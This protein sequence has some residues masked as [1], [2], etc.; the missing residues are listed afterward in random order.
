L[1]SSS[2]GDTDWAVKFWGGSFWIFL[3][4]AVYQVSRDRPADIQTVLSNT[5]RYVVGA[6]VSTC[7]PLQ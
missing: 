4:G 3:N 6:G 5:G 1:T 7:A 2:S